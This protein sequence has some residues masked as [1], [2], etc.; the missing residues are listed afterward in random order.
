MRTGQCLCSAVQYRA[1]TAEAVSV[2]Y[3]KMCQ[4]WASGAFMG[5]MAE[6]FE[7][8]AGSAHLKVAKTSEWAERGFCDQCGSNL[9][10]RVPEPG[11]IS[12]AFGSLDDTS[13]LQP[14]VQF[15]VDKRPEGFALA[16]KTKEMTEAECVAFF[17]PE[18]GDQP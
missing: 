9:F 3:C 13:G 17:A 8:T 11:H 10:Y 2:C 5:V 6:G 16:A 15:Y 1:Q 14:R 4:R 12:V 18:E 7:V